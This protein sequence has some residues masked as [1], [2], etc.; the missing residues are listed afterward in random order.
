MTLNLI[1]GEIGLRLEKK[2]VKKSKGVAQTLYA[3]DSKELNAIMALLSTY[4]PI[5]DAVVFEQASCVK[6]DGELNYQK[7]I[8]R[9]SQKPPYFFHKNS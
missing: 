5:T 3:F 7:F 6:P 8:E 2:K 1:F 4:T 9:Y